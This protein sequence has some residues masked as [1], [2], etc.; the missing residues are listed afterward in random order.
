MRCAEPAVP[1]AA[2]SASL[3]QRLDRGSHSVPLCG[4]VAPP[5]PPFASLP[6]PPAAAAAPPCSSSSPFS[7][8]PASPMAPVR[9]Y[10][11]PVKSAVR[12]RRPSAQNVWHVICAGTPL[13]V[14]CEVRSARKEAL[15]AKRVACHMCMAPPPTSPLLFC[16]SQDHEPLLEP[17]PRVA[18]PAQQ[19]WQAGR[20]RRRPC[21][22]RGLDHRNC[23]RRRPPRCQ[24]VHRPRAPAGVHG[25]PPLPASRCQPHCRPRLR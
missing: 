1:N 13:R 23:R 17:R 24:R 11:L 20:R 7:L 8:S 25:L 15:C 3:P 18:H 2:S 12:A 10:E 9:H 16:S 22:R 4:F 19:A 14:A 21:R 5:G 6:P